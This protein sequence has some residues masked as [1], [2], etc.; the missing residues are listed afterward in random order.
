MKQILLIL[1]FVTFFSSQSQSNQEIDS[2][3]FEMCKELN[4]QEVSNDSIK[5]ENVFQNIFYPYL[6]NIAAEKQ[7]EVYNKVAFRFQRN[8]S[9][10]R[11]ILHRMNPPKDEVT[12][13]KEEP[14]SQI[15]SKE[16]ENFKQRKTFSYKE[17]DGKETKVE[18]NNGYWI[19][20]F[21]DQ[22]FSKLSLEW[23]TDN[24]FE[25]IFI[26]SDNL[27]RANF[28]FKGDK[29]FYKVL[30]K[31]DDHYLVGG[32]IEGQKDFEIF[33]LYFD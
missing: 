7:E 23:I 18:I 13:R 4:S 6:E 21:S 20:H 10:I 25:L 14:K 11:E 1:F 32:N 16:L 31:E 8:C 33:K 26:E 27:S 2:L 28:S 30:S 5:I 9:E 24:K 12:F 3:T 17:G 15:S 19:D 22:T 29:M